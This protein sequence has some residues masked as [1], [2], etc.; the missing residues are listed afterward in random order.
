MDFIKL[1]VGERFEHD[2]PEEGMSIVLANG[3]PLLTFNFSVSPGEIQAFL[4]GAASFALFAEQN[5]VFFLF[6]IEG[7]LDWSDL[8]FTIH[9]AGD[10]DID[11]GDAYLPFNLVLVEPN[12]KIVKGLRMVTVSPDFRSRLAEL[13]RKQ[14][15][16]PFDTMAY[17]RG[18]G[19]L[20][21]KYPTASDLLKQ[22]VIIEQGG[23]TLPIMHT[24]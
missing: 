13:I 6:K 12:T 24:R 4:N 10:E 8:A 17:Y 23:K 18:I 20:Y 16:E 3:A 9:L 2:M 1:C 19:S 22:A 5:H 15:S 21:D 14:A 11:E 7:F